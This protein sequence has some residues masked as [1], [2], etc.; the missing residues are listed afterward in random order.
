MSDGKSKNAYVIQ[1]NTDKYWL[2]GD[3][4]YLINPPNEKYL[5]KK[6]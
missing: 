3:S 5:I 2:S 1:K 4:V 6:E